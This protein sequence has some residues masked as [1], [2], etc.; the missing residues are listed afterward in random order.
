METKNGTISYI[1]F[2]GTRIHPSAFLLAKSGSEPQHSPGR[3]VP[4]LK[5]TLS[6]HK[7]TH[8]IFI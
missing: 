8:I 4:R 7:Y 2:L 3:L 1:D 6:L 5:I